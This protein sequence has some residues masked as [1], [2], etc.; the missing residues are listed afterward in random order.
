MLLPVVRKPQE[1]PARGEDEWLRAHV[2]D[3]LAFWGRLMCFSEGR[4][5]WAGSG[6]QFVEMRFKDLD[7]ALRAGYAQVQHRVEAESVQ[8]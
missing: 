1:A 2:E 7:A 6:G 8:Q 3:S 5:A 4:R